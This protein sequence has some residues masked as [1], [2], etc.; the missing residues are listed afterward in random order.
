MRYAP[1]V[2]AAQFPNAFSGITF[3]IPEKPSGHLKG[4]EWRF[5]GAYDV[6][7]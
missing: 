6:Q 4:G 5:S 1:A 7:E 3:A 2:F